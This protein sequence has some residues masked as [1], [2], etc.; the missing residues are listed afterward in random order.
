MP[1]FFIYGSLKRGMHNNQILESLK[2]RY[3]RTTQTQRV[4]KLVSF[5]S[6]PGLV[7]GIRAIRGEL[8]DVPVEGIDILDSL[9]EVDYMYN[10]TTTRLATGERAFVY[11]CTPEF[12]KAGRPYLKDVWLDDDTP[13]NRP[14][15][16]SQAHEQVKRR[17]FRQRLRALVG[18]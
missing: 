7:P 10:R 14:T 5:R 3:L 6:F 8:W 16:I 4:F 18:R 9:E 15:S 11:V 2:A 17:T 12:G 1:L 13:P